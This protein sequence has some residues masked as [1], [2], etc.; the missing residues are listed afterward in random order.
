MMCSGMRQNERS[1]FI[2][3]ILFLWLGLL[4]LFG[5]GNGISVEAGF[6]KPV[7]FAAVV[8]LGLIAVHLSLEKW[9]FRGDQYLFPLTSML[10]AAGL[11]MILRLEPDYALRQSIWLFIGLA[12][13][14]VTVR[15]LHNY[16]R[17]EDYKYIYIFAALIMLLAT[18][19]FGA[20]A[21]GA[22]S[23]IDLG[24]A[25][26]QP[27]EFVKIVL[28]I[29]LASYLEEK[30]EVLAEGTR[31]IWGISIPGIQYIGPLLI[32]WGFSL[33]LLIFQK[34]LGTALIF[35]GTFLVMIYISTGRWPYV[36][37]GSL[38]FGFGA[39]ACYLF[40]GHVRVRVAIWLNPWTDIEG[41]GYQIIQSLFALGSGGIFGTGIGLG[42]PN[43]IP[44]VHTDF[45]FSAWS[46]ETGLI[47]AI[48]LLI[49]YCLIIYRGF[50]IALAA[51]TGFGAL[52]AAG[53]TSLLAVQTLV[54]VGG[55]IKLLPLTGVTLPFVSYGGSSLVSS[56]IMLGILM[57]ISAEG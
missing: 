48:A 40:F 34:D 10:S 54:I 39:A 17:L 46:E 19:L 30:K 6:K 43:L 44:A 53:L 11:V 51:H 22:R 9:R 37:F 47:G 2:Y 8:S 21:G 33:A 4:S 49:I 24:I 31:S 25:K 18:I 55:V 41:K 32:M 3:V 42:Q 56:Y 45:V 16:K 14:L 35:F 12:A 57:R 20:E 38:L 29:F 27:S 28:V 1:L 5:A 36:F 52:L 50:R 26:F 23:W 15:L 13:F 7:L